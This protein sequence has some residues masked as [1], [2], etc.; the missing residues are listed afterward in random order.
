[1]TRITQ[2]VYDILEVIEARKSE[3]MYE[4]GRSFYA[5]YVGYSER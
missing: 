5:N 1:M 2:N 4:I 3:R